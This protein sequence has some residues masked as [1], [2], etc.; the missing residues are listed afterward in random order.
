VD[1]SKAGPWHQLLIVSLAYRQRAIP[2]AWMWVGCAR[3]HSTAG[4]QLALL[5]AL[6]RL[7]PAE[8]QVLLVGDQEF[9]TVEVL[10]QLDQWGW[11]YVLHQ[12]GNTLIRQN[13]THPWQAFHSLIEKPGRC[14]WLGAMHLTQQHRLS[15]QS[16]DLLAAG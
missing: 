4:R 12:K 10:Q 2:L 3:G 16:P 8:A 6:R 11:S 7:L 1:G 13:D 5:K 14:V 15:G 9:G